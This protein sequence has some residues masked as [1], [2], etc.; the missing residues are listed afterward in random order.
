MFSSRTKF[1]LFLALIMIV[2]LVTW[3]YAQQ[4]YSAFNVNEPVGSGTPFSQV[5]GTETVSIT[6]PPTFTQASTLTPTAVEGALEETGC[7]LPLDYWLQNQTR[8]PPQI[9]LNVLAAGQIEVCVNYARSEICA[10]LGEVSNAADIILKQQFLVTIMNYLS[11]AD[12]SA[13][14]N[15]INDAYEWLSS[16]TSAEIISE[17]DLQVAQLYAQT[18][19][20]YNQGE[21]GP[22]A[23]EEQII[24]LTQAE[25]P[26][27][28][29]T[30]GI[31]TTV[32]SPTVTSTP[33]VR[34][35]AI[36][37]VP[38]STEAP[39]RPGPTRTSP[40]P[41]TNTLPAPTAT[42]P[43]T[44]TE[45]PPTTQIPPP[46]STDIPTPTPVPEEATPTPVP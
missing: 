40:P 45:I 24:P 2:V 19:Q 22:G 32:S 25:V 27:S 30:P 6:L 14:E 16:H 28:S 3:L 43:P 9:L 36:I 20:S 39:S 46:T 42:P 5:M 10:I 35:T 13:I 23:C 31:T 33:T 17:Q 34:R 18:L 4:S 26:T 41:A 38:T 37:I 8:I 15:T 11:G 29:P 21:I 44:A 7:T 12:P 1:L